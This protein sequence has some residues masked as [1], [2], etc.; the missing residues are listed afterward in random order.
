[1][2]DSLGRGKESRKERTSLVVSPSQG[3]CPPQNKL[4][5]PKVRERKRCGEAISAQAERRG[6]FARWILETV[7]SE[8]QR[9][10]RLEEFLFK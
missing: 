4:L 7:E 5:S 3:T 2:L 9:K 1:M 8:A 10:G 6:Q